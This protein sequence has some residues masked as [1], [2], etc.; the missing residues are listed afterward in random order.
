MITE[1]G[2]HKVKCGC[3]M[4][5]IEDLMQDT[6]VDFIYSDPPWGQG[7]LKYWQTI[8]KR[9]TGK[10]PTEIDFQEFLWHY[11]S[12]LNKY[13]KHHAI[14]CIEY[15]IRWRSDIKKMCEAYNLIWNG[16]V[17]SIYSSDNLKLD[18]HIISKSIK[19]DIPVSLLKKIL[20]KKGYDFVKLMFDE[21]APKNGLVLDPMCGMGFTA[22]ACIDNNLIF[23]GNELNAKRL[24]K[25][26][27][28]LKKHENIS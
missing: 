13:T 24:D 9:H 17:E 1:I 22:Q 4:Q 15:G 23:Y 5:G 28:R 11:F 20:N 7:N 14:M 8:N 19:A 16:Y 21:Y 18:V 3:I 27:K 2:K 12:L 26:I 25:T 10:E 6:K